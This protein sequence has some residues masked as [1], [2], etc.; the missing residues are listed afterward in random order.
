MC[1]KERENM[2]DFTLNA[3]GRVAMVID[4]CSIDRTNEE[5]IFVIAHFVDSN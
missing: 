1:V 2:K 4:N 3:L 5:Y